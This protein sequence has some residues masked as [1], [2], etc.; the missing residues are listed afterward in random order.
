MKTLL[1]VLLSLPLLAQPKIKGQVVRLD[2]R[3][4]KLVPKEAVIEELAAGFEW[5]EGPVWVKA[6]TTEPGYLLFSDVPKNTVYRWTEADGCKPFLMPSGYTGRGTY[7][8]EPGS[9]GLTLDA[10][11]RLISC[12]HGDRRI[13]AMPLSGVGGK[14]TLADRYK[15]KRFNSPNDVVQHANGSF[16]FTDPPYGLAKKEADPSRETSVLGVYRIDPAGVVSLVV[17]DLTRPNGLAFSPDQKTLYVA[18]SDMTRPVIMAYPVQ[19]DGSVG[20]GRLVYD[21]SALMKQGLKG[22][23]DGIKVDSQGNLWSTGPG[24]VLV[25][26]LDPKTG[27]GT[28]L[29]RIDTGEAT[30]NCG[31]GDDG[32]T[33]YLT[34]DGYLCR[35]KTTARGAGW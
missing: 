6:T 4:D 22:A 1:L 29:G 32:S 35:I 7:S 25:L 18:Q 17:G 9:N 5:A 31:W 21:A 14:I 15:G 27:M 19:K 30:A 34:A 26:A 10:Q 3:F 13:S 28:L 12:E 2:P 11:G 16:Y 33:L 8:D 20:A 24:G 23:P